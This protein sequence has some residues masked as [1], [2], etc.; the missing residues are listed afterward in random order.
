MKTIVTLLAAAAATAA[1]PGSLI[2][3]G[4]FDGP[5]PG[6]DPKGVELYATAAIADLS[7]YGLE[8]ASNGGASGGAPEATLPA[9]TLAA[10]EFYYVSNRDDGDFAQWFGF[11]ANFSGPSGGA[12]NHNGDDVLLLYQSGAVIDSFGELGVDGSGTPWET[13]DGWAYRNNGVS[14]NGGTFDAGNWSFSGPNAWDGNDHVNGGSDNG[15][16]ATATPPFPAGT[17]QIPEPTSTLLGGLGLGLLFLL[18][19]KK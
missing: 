17:F 12:V 3:T 2:I 5:L 6:G 9:D 10:G 15:T 19:R 14:A 11:A 18:R 16:N 8:T 1:A 4:V 7:I 13:L